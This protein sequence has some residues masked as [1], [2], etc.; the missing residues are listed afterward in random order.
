MAD[1]AVQTQREGEVLTVAQQL[2]PQVRSCGRGEKTPGEEARKEQKG[3][4]EEVWKTK[5]RRKRRKENR[6][7]GGKERNIFA[8][9]KGE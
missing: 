8:G 3:T 9:G 1:A 6:R 4:K 5:E 2:I 7:C